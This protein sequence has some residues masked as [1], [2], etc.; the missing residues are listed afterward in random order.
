VE[1]PTEEEEDKLLELALLEEFGP[2][3]V[4]GVVESV[5]VGTG[6]PVMVAHLLTQELILAEIVC[7]VKA[8]LGLAIVDGGCA[9]FVE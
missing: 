4:A 3:N 5:S 6:A 7:V 1:I 2:G 8:G 9:N